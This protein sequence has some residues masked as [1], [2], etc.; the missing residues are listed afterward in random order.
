MLSFNIYTSNLG[1]KN[2]II[3]F[4]YII[5]NMEIISYNTVNLLVFCKQNPKILNLLLQKTKKNQQ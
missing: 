4:F 1:L 3:Y 2:V 5:I